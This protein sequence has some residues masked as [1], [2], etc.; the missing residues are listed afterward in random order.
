MDIDN[1]VKKGSFYEAVVEDGSDIIFVVDYTG[2]IRYHN[3]S[4]LTN[5]WLPLEEPYQGRTSLTIS[6]R[7]P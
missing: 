6:C 3:A 1:Y 5:P 4:A 7:I 2:R